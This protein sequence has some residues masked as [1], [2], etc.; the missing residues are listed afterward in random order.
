M[1]PTSFRPKN[2][3]PNW[4][5]GFAEGEDTWGDCHDCLCELACKTSDAAM[6]FRRNVYAHLN[7]ARYRALYDARSAIGHAADRLILE[8][9][10]EECLAPQQSPP[11]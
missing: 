5:K 6:A 9:L 8:H 10:M 4:I 2:T 11:P 1:T 7:A 3:N